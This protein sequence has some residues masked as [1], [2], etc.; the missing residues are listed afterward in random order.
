MPGS[1]DRLDAWVY[2][3]GPRGKVYMGWLGTSVHWSGAGTRVHSEV[4]LSL[5]SLFLTGELLGQGISLG[6]VLHRL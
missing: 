1:I 6:A 5:C 4:G 2:D 3:D